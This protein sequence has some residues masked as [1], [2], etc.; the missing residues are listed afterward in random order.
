MT[1]HYKKIV[2]IVILLCCF[3]AFLPYTPSSLIDDIKNPELSIKKKNEK[4][5]FFKNKG[6]K[7]SSRDFF[8]IVQCVHCNSKKF[9]DIEFLT[10]ILHLLM[11]HTELEKEYIEKTDKLV[12]SFFKRYKNNPKI[13]ASYLNLSTKLYTLSTGIEKAALK[14]KSEIISKYILE[15]NNDNLLLYFLKNKKYGAIDSMKYSLSEPNS[16]ELIRFDIYKFPINK[17]F[18]TKNKQLRI[19]LLDY[20]KHDYALTFSFTLDEIHRLVYF[21]LNADNDE[22][23]SK[24]KFILSNRVFHLSQKETLKGFLK[25]NFSEDKWSK[26]N[27]P[28]YLASIL[29]RV[30]VSEKTK[31]LV[32]WHLCSRISIEVEDSYKEL[33]LLEK[34]ILNTT[35]CSS[36]QLKDSLYQKLC[37]IPMTPNSQNVSKEAFLF[38]FTIMKDIPENILPTAC[39]SYTYYSEK[40]SNDE[41]FL[42][43]IKLELSK[44]LEKRLSKSKNNLSLS[45]I[46]SGYTVLGHKKKSAEILFQILKNTKPKE[47]ENAK[48]RREIMKKLSKL[49]QKNDFEKRKQLFQQLKEASLYKNTKNSLQKLIDQDHDD[50]LDTWK[51]A[52][53]EMP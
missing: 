37:S 45:A 3:S 31:Q 49:N 20:L 23:P 13:F 18:S 2:S 28:D 1:N 46:A 4:I 48:R 29:K 16:R 15:E 50:N 39:I 14:R 35:W 33:K 5:I 51:K 44:E 7:L 12:L 26:F 8:D 42:K 11:F 32:L 6:L 52:I 17:F 43:K 40:F 19:L 21:L 9:E 53:S 36:K 22:I 27:F 25:S 30:D 10:S 47:Q 24:I 38:L 34:L 41:K